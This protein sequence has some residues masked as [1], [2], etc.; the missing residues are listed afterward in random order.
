MADFIFARK[1]RNAAS[2]AVHVLLNLV[3]AIFSV[4]ITVLTNSPILGLI[5]VV[6][7]KWRVFAVRPR[8]LWTNIKA[9]LL[10]F[11]VGASIILLTYF[12]GTTILPV[13]FIL[14]AFYCAWLIFIKPLTS[15]TANLIQSL[16]AVFLGTSTAVIMSSSLDPIVMVVL[17]FIIGYSASRHVLAQS[18][19]ED[20]ALTTL[21]CGLVFAEVAW[22]C[23]SWMIIYTFGNSG[24]RI[25]QLS[26]I[27]TIFAFIFNRARQSMLRRDGELKFRD[28]LAP[29]IFGVVVIGIILIWFSN[30]IFNI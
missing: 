8:Y 7:S 30:P 27:L 11:I 6:M 18:N 13:D 12:S 24:I 26:I 20:Y 15:E 29:T 17:A 23:Y 22:L 5:L 25:P 3:F 2:S 10:D 1:T 28:I 14:A 9:N 16:V 4:M 21:V 19:D